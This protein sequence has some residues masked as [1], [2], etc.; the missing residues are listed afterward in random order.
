ML[1]LALAL[2]PSAGDEPASA[3]LAPLRIAIE[4]ERCTLRVAAPASATEVALVCGAELLDRPWS[5]A[6]GERIA[7]AL[8]ADGLIP[9]APR[10]ESSAEH[11]VELPLAAVRVALGERGRY[12]QAR[13]RTDDGAWALGSAWHL[14]AT[15][16]N[17]GDASLELRSARRVAAERAAPAWL[18]LVG[19]LAAAIG[20]GVALRVAHVRGALRSR[21]L[22]L[23]VPALLVCASLA[24]APRAAR[25][26]ADLRW[27]PEP[28]FL[29]FL[30]RAAERVRT[31]PPDLLVQIDGA[32]ALRC[33]A[34]DALPTAA[35]AHRVE[36]A[37]RCARLGPGL[38]PGLDEVEL[39]RWGEWSLL[40]P[41]P[42][43]ESR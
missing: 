35:L 12:V 17:A 2:G 13:W 26:L 19:V 33:R 1:A 18:A 37:A 30:A 29:D 3:E 5:G 42:F 7:V 38:V 25:E 23:A 28:E 14:R 9:L 16:T 43:V 36:G 11:G 41:R 15:G 39:E 22:V 27:R 8:D 24:S 40:A 10:A 34:A 32:P 4:G 20:V 6:G 31:W 21:T